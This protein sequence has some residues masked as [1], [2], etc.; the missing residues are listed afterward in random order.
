MLPILKVHQEQF[1]LVRCQ[2]WE[3]Y[4]KL[5]NFKELSLL[6][7]KQQ[8]EILE[9]EFDE[10]FS[11]HTSYKKL[12]NRLEQTFL[13][14]EKLLQVLHFPQVP[15]HNNA[16]ELAV[17]RKARKRDIHLHTMSSIGIRAQ[18]AFMTVV[19]TAAKLG[20]NVFEYLLDLL[21][22]KREMIP[23]ADLIAI[24]AK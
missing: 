7:Q 24:K 8:R 5:L 18:D 20:V 12:N 15:L 19:E 23:L 13:R 3:Y 4:K 17:R 22:D 14:K 21:S 2:I 16:A 11:Q 6:E 10:I 1:E 9:Q